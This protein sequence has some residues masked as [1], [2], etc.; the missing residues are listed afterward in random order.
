MSPALLLSSSSSGNDFHAVYPFILSRLIFEFAFVF[1]CLTLSLKSFMLFF[2][3]YHYPHPSE[4]CQSI[5]IISEVGPLFGDLGEGCGVSGCF[6]NFIKRKREIVLKN[7]IYP[8]R[9]IEKKII[10][11]QG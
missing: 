11:F 3:I 8:L 7:D 2:Y 4:L 1:P 10:N 6:V 9:F 5:L